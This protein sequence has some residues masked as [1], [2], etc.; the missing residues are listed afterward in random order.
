MNKDQR[1]EH[2][3]KYIRSVKRMESAFIKPVYNALQ[4]QI[5]AFTHVLRSKGIYAAK[6]ELESVV[7]D[8][9]IAE[10][11]KDIYTTIGIYSANRTLA[12]IGKS[13]RPIKFVK[14]SDIVES[15]LEFKGP[16]FGFNEELFHRI[17]E[18][19][20]LFLL[21]KAVLPITETTK[22]FIRAMLI[23][24]ERE[25]WGYDQTARE[26]ETSDLTL[27]RAR[28]IV[29]TESVKAMQY[30]RQQ[31]Q[32]K[33]RFE[34]ESEW[35]A[36]N[37]HRTRHSHRDVDGHTVAEGHLFNVPIYKGNVIVG[38]DHMTGPGDAHATAG[39]VINCRCT[40][41]TTAK[42]DESGRL[43]P[44]KGKYSVILQ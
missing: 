18:Y 43:I 13:V 37:D 33:S 10:V 6:N 40:M 28:M 1:I 21:N 17:I 22:D 20:K 24:G 12:E 29:R 25:G 3:A 16:G 39:N 19:F 15:S 42:R 4:K 2:S 32:S 11:I 26:L 23:K 5:K 7:I 14:S 38:H 30:G 35:I 27:S 41:A 36:A 44:K 31:G 9:H 8:D 34:T